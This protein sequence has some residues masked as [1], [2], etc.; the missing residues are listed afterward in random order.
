M[1]EARSVRNETIAI[2]NESMF[3]RGKAISRQPSCSG[4]AR[5]VFSGAS[6]NTKNTMIVPCSVMSER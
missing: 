4:R 5:Y 1:Q 2:Q 6:V 3:S